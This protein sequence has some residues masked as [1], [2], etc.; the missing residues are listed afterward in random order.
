MAQ[1]RVKQ[2]SVG[3]NEAAP[4][5]ITQY[6]VNLYSTTSNGTAFREIAW[7]TFRRCSVRSRT[8]LGVKW[9]SVTSNG[10]ALREMV[11]YTSKLIRAIINEQ[12]IFRTSS[13]MQCMK[14]SIWNNRVLETGFRWRDISA[15][16]P[17]KRQHTNGT[18]KSKLRQRSVWCHPCDTLV[19]NLEEA[20]SASQLYCGNSPYFVSQSPAVRCNSTI[21]AYVISLNISTQNPDTHYISMCYLRLCLARIVY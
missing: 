5:K 9:Y 20:W 3:S 12:K 10:T 16:K 8:Q 17:P 18:A 1:S 21:T 11:Q 7:H 2:F 15:P 19:P 4:D 13:A 6:S 14:H